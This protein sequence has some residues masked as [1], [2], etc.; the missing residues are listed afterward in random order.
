MKINGTALHA[1]SAYV[2]AA[3]SM[4]HGP[5]STQYRHI[6]HMQP[7][8]SPDSPRYA[9]G[10]IPHPAHRQPSPEEPAHL[11]AL[12]CA[13]DYDPTDALRQGAVVISRFSP[14]S[15]PP[16]ASTSRHSGSR[17]AEDVISRSMFPLTTSA[18]T[19]MRCA[20]RSQGTRSALSV[21]APRSPVRLS[22]ALSGRRSRAHHDRRCRAARAD[23]IVMQDT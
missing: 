4:R 21:P 12:S 11:R 23:T 15:A 10:R 16:N 13:D 17:L 18:M 22:Q 2:S 20:S 14:R 7:G 5:I 6:L 9:S 3:Q 8:S 1:N 19:G